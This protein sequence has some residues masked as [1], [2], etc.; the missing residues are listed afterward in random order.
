MRRRR[1]R[2]A[3]AE[4]QKNDDGM[5]VDADITSLSLADIAFDAKTLRVIAAAEGTMSVTVTTLPG[6]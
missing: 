5:Q 6:L 2:E 4:F 1:S 3:I